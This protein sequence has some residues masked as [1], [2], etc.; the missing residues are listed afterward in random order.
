M[1]KGIINI[2]FFIFII[3]TGCTISK[4]P[5]ISTLETNLETSV[6]LSSEDEIENIEQESQEIEKAQELEISIDDRN[7]EKHIIVITTDILNVR[8]TPSIESTIISTVYERS[9]YTV[10]DIASDEVDNTWYKIHYDDNKVGWIA[11]WYTE[12]TKENI[13]FRSIAEE[14]ATIINERNYVAL[15]KFVGIR[16]LNLEYVF[17]DYDILYGDAKINKVK[18]SKEIGSTKYYSLV[19]D[20][21]VIQEINISPSINDEI[22]LRDHVIDYSIDLNN[23]MSSYINTLKERSW[24]DALCLL[25]PY[26][27]KGVFPNYNEDWLCN[28]EEHFDLESINWK[29]NREINQLEFECI[30]YGEKDSVYYEHPII[31]ITSNGVVD[32]IDNFI[33][34]EYMYWE[35]I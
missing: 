6:N 23:T 35:G 30:I 32:L 31:V 14:F 10:I 19:Y 16:A 29:L 13:E 21:G 11:S 3:L 7:S 15:N 5:E 25:M 20:T 24:D 8:Q 18:L 1:I 2:T 28:Y 4:T 22:M 26:E 33:M 34:P 9:V 12:P 17:D 27:Y